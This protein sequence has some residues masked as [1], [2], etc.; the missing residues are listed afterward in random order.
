MKSEL[1][2]RLSKIPSK[3]QRRKAMPSQKIRLSVKDGLIRYTDG[4]LEIETPY[5]FNVFSLICRL[6]MT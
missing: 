6:L 5:D 4:T 3:R 1:L 2:E